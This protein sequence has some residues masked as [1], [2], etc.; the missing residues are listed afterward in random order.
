MSIRS[1]LPIILLCAGAGAWA[2]ARLDSRSSMHITLPD[3]SPVALLSADW[4]ESRAD[5][6]GGALVLDLHTALSFKNS[7]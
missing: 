6:R 4:G 7:S 2:Q 3:D 5:N 1:R